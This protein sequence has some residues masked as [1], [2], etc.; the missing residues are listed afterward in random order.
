MKFSHLGGKYFNANTLLIFIIIYVI[1][2][3][4]L[5]IEFKF[6]FTDKFYSDALTESDKSIQEI[7]ELIKSD[8]DQQWINYPYVLLVIFAPTIATMFLLYIG[9]IFKEHELKLKSIFRIS[10]ESH[11]VFACSYFIIVIMKVLKIIKITP[12]NVNDWFGLQS[13]LVFFK[14]MD[15]PVWLRYPLQCFNLTELLFVFALSY[16]YAKITQSKYLKS[17]GWVALVYGL[18]LIFWIILS[19]FIDIVLL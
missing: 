4:S 15:I 1:Y 19:I 10:L 2:A 8:R 13:A 17:L 18:G 9:A 6:I 7:T 16:G 5:T 14:Q 12:A 3:I 11:A